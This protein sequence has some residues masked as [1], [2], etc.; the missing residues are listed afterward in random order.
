MSLFKKMKLVPD[1][2]SS[3][4]KN[5]SKNIIRYETPSNLRQMNDLDDEMKKILN[6]D[7]DEYTKSKLYS[8][9]LRKFILL[10]KSNSQR[11]SVNK[12]PVCLDIYPEK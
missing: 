6:S 4:N 9:A 11:D 2:Q 7:L 12:I 8:E 1:V 10:K 3:N 5:D